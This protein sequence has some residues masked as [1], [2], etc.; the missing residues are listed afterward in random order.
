[1]IR[2]ERSLKKKRLHNRG[3]WGK[4]GGGGKSPP[5]GFQEKRG[6]H[7]LELLSFR[8]EST[9]KETEERRSPKLPKG[10]GDN[11]REGLVGR[12][13]GGRLPNHNEHKK[14]YES[15]LIMMIS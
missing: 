9:T 15:V 8:K 7:K 14:D 4:G 11:L 6:R 3:L 1:M 13:R 12:K 10:E 5:H 2:D